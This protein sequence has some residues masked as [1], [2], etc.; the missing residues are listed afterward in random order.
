MAVL[1]FSCMVHFFGWDN[2]V[3]KESEAIE[4]AAARYGG[5]NHL[6]RCA[7]CRRPDGAGRFAGH[8]TRT[9]RRRER[10]TACR[11]LPGLG[12]PAAIYPADFLL[13]A[14]GAGDAQ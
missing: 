7:C 8:P 12:D 6:N 2:A 3:E 5:T 9:L 10:A 13:L 1:D 14:A 4:I 11:K